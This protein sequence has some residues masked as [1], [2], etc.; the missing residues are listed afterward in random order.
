MGIG[1]SAIKIQ[2]IKAIGKDGKDGI[3]G[4]DGF[5]PMNYGNNLLLAAI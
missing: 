3:N 4:K 5:S 2:K 1:I